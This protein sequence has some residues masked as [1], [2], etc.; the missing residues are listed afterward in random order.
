[1][2]L[3]PWVAGGA[4]LLR[5]EWKKFEGDK[6]VAGPDAA[7]ARISARRFLGEA[8]TKSIKHTTSPD[9]DLSPQDQIHRIFTDALDVDYLDHGSLLDIW[10]SINLMEGIVLA[11]HAGGLPETDEDLLLRCRTIGDL[12][13]ILTPDAVVI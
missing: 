5:W 4:S 2:G 12:I 9:T 1:M 7:T 6:S 13:E 11:E 10:P 8:D 3:L